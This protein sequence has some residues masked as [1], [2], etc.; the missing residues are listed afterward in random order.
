M[1]EVQVGSAN[2]SV[3]KHVHRGLRL[4][5]NDVAEKR[6]RPFAGG[7]SRYHVH[8]DDLV[9]NRPEALDFDLDGPA[10]LALDDILVGELELYRLAAMKLAQTIL[11]GTGQ[12]QRGCADVHEHAALDGLA[13]A[14]EVGD[15]GLGDDSTQN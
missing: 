4:L 11:P 13:L 15:F 1:L 2:E 9:G 10:N 8:E 3:A 14:E 5:K 6:R 7:A 12:E